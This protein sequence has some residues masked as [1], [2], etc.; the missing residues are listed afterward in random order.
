MTERQP[1]PDIHTICPAA[2]GVRPPIPAQHA[3][4]SDQPALPY[5]V[6]FPGPRIERIAYY[7]A[8]LVARRPASP[9][10]SYR[11]INH[12]ARPDGPAPP[13]DRLCAPRR[14]RRRESTGDVAANG[15]IR[16]ASPATTPPGESVPWWC[17]KYCAR[18]SRQ[19]HQNY[20]PALSV[21]RVRYSGLALL[22]ET[23]S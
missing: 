23:R 7:Q 9:V 17:H 13:V 2:H 11:P 20:D 6:P 4:I 22:P 12:I 14:R 18:I 15:L 8:R 1:G 5:G 21:L 10:Q 3:T 19:Y 16:P